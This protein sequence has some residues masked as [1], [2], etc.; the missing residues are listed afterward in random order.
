MIHGHYTV[1][2]FFEPICDD[3][4]TCNDCVC[5]DCPHN[6]CDDCE[7]NAVTRGLSNI[8]IG[9]VFADVA[10]ELFADGIPGVEF[11]PD[12]TFDDD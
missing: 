5:N 9:G 7:Y 8:A 11:D 4:E 1:D 10:N 2:G 12:F 6:T 3:D